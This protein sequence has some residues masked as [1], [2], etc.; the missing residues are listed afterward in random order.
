MEFWKYSALGNTFLVI[1]VS[2]PPTA[3]RLRWILQACAGRS[4]VFAD[5]AALVHVPTARLS[6]YNA[7]GRRAEVSGNG[8]RSAAAWWFT[9]QETG[10][11]EIVW[12]T[13]AGPIDCRLR[14]TRNIEVT[15]PPPRFEAKAVPVRA[16][17]RE[18]WGVPLPAGVVRTPGLR[19]F[20]LSVGNPQ[21]VVWVRHFPADWRQIG[22]ALSTHRMFPDET[23]V[24]FA[25]K[26]GRGLEVR[27]FE[28]GVGETAS[29]GTGAAAA[30]IVSSQLGKTARKCTVRMAGG[31]MRVHWL[32][33]GDIRLSGGVA[34]IA[35]GQLDRLAGSIR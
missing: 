12:R 16:R 2:R 26:S 28:R 5:G 17:A 15:L 20:A 19:M 4:G 24:V 30:A 13:D 9:E 18:L 35:H 3:H 23:N 34:R 25:R 33:D 6:I 1:P 32:S 22:E 21:C 10:A 31:T 8:A 11:R 14:G 29:S 7:D 27:L